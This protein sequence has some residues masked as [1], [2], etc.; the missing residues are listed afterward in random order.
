VGAQFFAELRA[1]CPRSRKAP[2][3]VKERVEV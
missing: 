3:S 1:L 2:Q